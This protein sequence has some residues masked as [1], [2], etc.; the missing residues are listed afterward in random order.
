MDWF[1]IG[2]GVWWGY[3]SLAVCIMS[4]CLFN[5]YAEYIMQSDRLDHNL[6]SRLPG[7]IS[8][9]DTQMIPL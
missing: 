5:L 9:S 7:K 4:L 8:T 2:K 3:M 6:E 1:Q